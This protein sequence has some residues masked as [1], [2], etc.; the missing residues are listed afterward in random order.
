M[1]VSYNFWYVDSL[2]QVTDWKII[3][4]KN[5]NTWIILTNRLININNLVYIEYINVEN[6]KNLYDVYR[7]TV[8]LKSQWEYKHRMDR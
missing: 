1:S 6:K 2:L 7:D 3:F 5:E 4:Q 8:Y